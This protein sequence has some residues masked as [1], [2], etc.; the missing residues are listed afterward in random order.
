MIFASLLI[1]QIS[2]GQMSYCD[3]TKISKAD[4]KLIEQFWTD[5]KKAVNTENK[6]KLSSLIKFSFSCD[7]CI[8]DSTK[9]R[10][11]DYLKV[12]RKL[13]DKKQYKI[14]F[15]T[16]LKKTIN[17]YSILFDIFI[18]FGIMTK[19]YDRSCLQSF[20]GGSLS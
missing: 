6:A 5:F 17:K 1:G 4:R 12:T 15:D 8:L 11:Y 3:K 9:G 19:L 10:N 18:L 7:Y 2:I 16:K 20:E 14:F 13:F